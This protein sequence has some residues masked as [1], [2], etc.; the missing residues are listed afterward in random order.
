MTGNYC[1]ECIPNV[2]TADPDVL[3]K[4]C[5]AIHTVPQVDLRF[6]DPGLSANRNCIHLHRTRPRQSSK[7]QSD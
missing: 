6:V 2:S 4:I 5:A 1:I 3:D 7:P